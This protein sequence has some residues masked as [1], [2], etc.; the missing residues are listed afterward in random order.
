MLQIN[1]PEQ[2][3]P[4][5]NLLNSLNEF[6]NHHT[7]FV[8]KQAFDA[9]N[10]ATDNV[11]EARLATVDNTYV[12]QYATNDIITNSGVPVHSAGLAQPA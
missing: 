4:Q 11:K 10:V 7:G 3:I 6:I 1:I 2:L 12:I 9:A 5:I 8:F